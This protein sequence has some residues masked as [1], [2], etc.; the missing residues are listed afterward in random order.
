MLLLV[1]VDDYVPVDYL[2]GVFIDI[3]I[4]SSFF[5]S[6]CRDCYYICCFLIFDH[7]IALI[8]CCTYFRATIYCAD[9]PSTVICLLFCL[10]LSGLSLSSFISSLRIVHCNQQHPRHYT[11]SFHNSNSNSNS[12]SSSSSNSS[13]N[14]RRRIF[15]YCSTWSLSRATAPIAARHRNL[16][17]RGY[18]QQTLSF[19][20]P[21]L[22]LLLLCRQFSHH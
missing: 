5:D 9:F 8:W 3:W 11:I 15:R 20:L 2:W 6:W 18:W 10:H 4:N 12:N 16:L 22:L 7:K 17:S 21:L 13:S 1:P 19:L 14:I